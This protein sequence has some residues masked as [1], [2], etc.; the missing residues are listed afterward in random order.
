MWWKLGALALLAVAFLALILTP[1]GTVD[2]T[3]E[4]P[5]PRGTPRAV[6]TGVFELTATLIAYGMIAAVLALIGWM[7]WRVVRHHRNTQA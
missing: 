6:D 7:M 5:R 3:V 2:I 4:M 1:I